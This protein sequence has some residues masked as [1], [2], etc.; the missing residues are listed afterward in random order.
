MEENEENKRVREM[1]NCRNRKMRKLWENEKI[2][3]LGA[4]RSQVASS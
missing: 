1:R 3:E 4:D 2:V